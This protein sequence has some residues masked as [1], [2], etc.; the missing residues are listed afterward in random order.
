MCFTAPVGA[1]AVLGR[2]H[3]CGRVQ[4]WGPSRKIR[5]IR[6][7]TFFLEKHYEAS[8]KNTGLRPK[9][10]FCPTTGQMPPEVLAFEK[11]VSLKVNALTGTTKKTYQNM[12]TAEL[13]ALK[14]LTSDPM[15]IIKPADKGGATPF[16]LRDRWEL[17]FPAATVN[18]SLPLVA[19]G[20]ESSGSGP[21]LALARIHAGAPA[22]LG[23]PRPFGL[24]DR[25][26]LHFPAA[27][28]NASLPLVALG[29]ESSGSGPTLALARIH[30]GAPALLGRP[31]PFGLRDRWEL[32]FPAATVNASLPLVALGPESSGSGPTLALARI[33]AGAPALLGRPRVR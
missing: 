16:G 29:P 17:H 4:G 24:R 18:A 2:R 6:L 3:E 23:R 14:G 22:L 1:P 12:S 33:H 26:E 9:S 8:D 19:L 30:A 20:P 32:H 21:T 27:T 10:T 31:R 11:S 7:K 13:S 15:I 28:V 25:W 5:K